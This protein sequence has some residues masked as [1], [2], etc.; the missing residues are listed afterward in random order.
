MTGVLLPA[1]CWTDVAG[2][3]C[4]CPS[5][6]PCHKQLHHA[7]GRE[8][9]CA[10]SKLCSRTI[11]HHEFQEITPTSSAP[12]E[13]RGPPGA[14]SARGEEQGA[15]IWA[16]LAKLLRWLLSSSVC[17]GHRVLNSCFL[18]MHPLIYPLLSTRSY[19]YMQI[20]ARQWP[21]ALRKIPSSPF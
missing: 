13:R 7:L 11:S 14:Q 8:Q 21:A 17:P 5:L 9:Q 1:P 4:R 2:C 19:L 6:F 12:F 15:R 16:Q 18:S 3:V 20:N 10:T